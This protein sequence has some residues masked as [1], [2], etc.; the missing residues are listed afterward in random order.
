MKKR[1]VI[2]VVI[3]A[4]IVVIV[5]SFFFFGG[6]GP[7]SFAGL[8]KGLDFSSGFNAVKNIMDASDANA[9]SN[10]ELN[11]FRYNQTG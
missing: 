7:L 6:R 10:I 9:F 11:P 8:F 5:L 2:I 3:I 1:T 4:V